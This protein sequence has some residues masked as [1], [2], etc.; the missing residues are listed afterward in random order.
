MPKIINVYKRL[1][2]F[3]YFKI[4]K[5]RNTFMFSQHNSIRSDSDNGLYVFEINKA[6]NNQKKFD[7]FKRNNGYRK[8]LEHVSYDQGLDYLSI[9]LKR[10]DYDI[11]TKIQDDSIIDDIGNPVK[12]YYQEINNKV[13]PTTLRYLKVVSD[14]RIL[15]GNEFKYIS[16]VGCGYGGQAYINDLFLNIEQQRLFDLPIVNELINKYLNYQLLSGSYST[17]SINTS[18]EVES[19]LII[20]NYAFSELPKKVQIKYINKVIIRSKRGYLTMNSGM[21]DGGRSQEKLSIKELKDQLPAFT[22][23]QEEPK[24]SA[25]NY[26]IVWGQEEKKMIE[27]FK[28]IN[29]TL[30][31][32]K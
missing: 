29:L 14:I 18:K 22:I 27:H 30:E 23:L 21:G 32:G 16:E 3:I 17:W 1:R 6:L 2:K 12:Y 28:E 15:F 5:F 8:I 31:I 26:I 20:S 24:T 11:I 7:N 4:M 13:S 25:N 10:Q 9:L 19:D